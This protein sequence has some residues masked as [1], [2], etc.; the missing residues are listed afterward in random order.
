MTLRKF[1]FWP[2]LIAGVLAGVVILVMSVTGV[3]LTYERQLIAWADSHFQ[4]TITER[5]PQRADVAVVLQQLKAAHPD[6]QPATVTFARDPRKPITVAAGQRT[7][8][9]DAYTGALLGESTGTMRKAMS[10]LRSWHRWL[11]VE[12]EGRTTARA[13]TGWSNLVFAFI[14]LS[15]MYLWLPK[16]WTWIQFRA[17]LLF[18]GKVRGKAR[19][20]NWHN[21]IGIWSAV[22]LF[23]VVVSA[24][25]I[26]FPWANAAVYK[27]MGEPVP[28]GRGGGGGE[29]GRGEG[30]ARRSPGEGGPRAAGREGDAGERRRQGGPN[31]EAQGGGR[32]RGERAEGDGGGRG[33]DAPLDVEGLAR[34]LALAE[35]QEPAW[36]TIALRLPANSAAPVSFN[37]DRGDGGQPHLRST[38]TLVR[39][40]GA[41]D[42]YETFAA[43]TPARRLR[44]ILRFAHTGEVLGIPGQ[45]IAGLV[46]AGSV[47]LVW[48]GIAL[49]LRRCRAWI[50][51]R[52][53]RSVQQ[54]L[55]AA[56][57]AA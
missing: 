15:G 7:F 16:A 34:L 40:T 43:Q 13:V 9:A 35:Q 32:Q 45:T 21:V 31:R 10:D 2:H 23:I 8:F 47:V 36:R 11:A 5:Y 56:D 28:A 51:R 22:P 33:A 17:V 19:D 6:V 30:P 18:N 57:S 12:G 42:T 53:R 29:R 1:I 55:P 14:V 24:V 20:F 27:A 3:L 38:L 37:I 44:S 49:S 25:P 48:T 41:I 54:P 52:S 50:A 39:A 4:S 46:T 26:S